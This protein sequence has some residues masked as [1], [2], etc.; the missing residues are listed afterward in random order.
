V[1][2]IDGTSCGFEPPQREYGGAYVAPE[3]VPRKKYG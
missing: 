2:H 3:D 1:Q